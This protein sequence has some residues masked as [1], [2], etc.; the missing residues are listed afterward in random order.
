MIKERIKH[1]ETRVVKSY[2]S[3]R[4]TMLS[5]L[6]F[7]LGVALLLFFVTNFLADR[8]IE[9]KYLSAEER[10]KRVEAYKDDLQKY[11]TDNDLSCDDTKE[12][13]KW[14]QAHKYLYV[15]IYKDDKLLF[16]SGQYE[17]EKTPEAD[18]EADGSEVL[19][20]T[21]TPDRDEAPDDNETPEGDTVVGEG[22]ENVTDPEEGEGTG[23]GDSADKEQPSDQ[24]GAE[25]PDGEETSDSTEEGGTVDETD[26]DDTS[27]NEPIDKPEGENKNENK[28]P[29]SG[30]TVKT[31]SRDELIAEAVAG[32][33]HP[34]V[35]SDGVLLA[36]MVDYTEYLYYDI[37]NIVSV[38]LAFAGFIL[39][40][41]IYFFE[42]TKRIT[43]LAREVTAVADGDMN[44]TITHEGEDE[45]TRLCTDVEYMR[46][47]MLEN[48]EKERAALEAN[49]ELITAMSHDIRTPLT[50]LLGYIDIMKLNAP[51]GDMQQYIEASERTALRLKKMSDDMFSYFLVYGGGIDVSVQECDARTLV[52][53]M[54][55]GHVFLLREQG[56]AIDFN[57]EYEDNDFLSD[58]IVVT[59]PPQLMRIVENIFSNIMK[60]ADT[61]KPV[62][63]FVGAEV[64][65]LT[66][67]VCN[68]IRP[69]PDEAQKNG[70]GLRSCMKLANAMDVRF[71]SAEEDGVFTSLMYVP[72][73]PTIEYT[74]SDGYEEIGGIIGWLKSILSKLKKS[75]GKLWRRGVTFFGGLLKGMKNFFARIFKRKGQQ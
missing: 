63:V 14:A 41:W 4:L 61:Q 18:T 75:L 49:R 43:R 19:P 70:I 30:I 62:T 46:S 54:L 36:S 15:L 53:Q 35:A 50:V 69:N 32:G 12:I 34:I 65:E 47:S 25:I 66:I 59:D 1:Q 5:T 20:D 58:V 26:K 71:S 57:F 2:S 64:D 9:H 16:E 6:L 22:G 31:P 44:H 38:I 11:V 7:A 56:Y 60:Y 33:S 28:Y 37:V 29:S 48:I 40:M 74:D 27:K 68:Y 67:K 73:I 45:I 21:E 51:D 72:I 3:L 55:S 8:Y 23:D 17:E 10:E 42:I 39:V 24:E 52:D 13:S